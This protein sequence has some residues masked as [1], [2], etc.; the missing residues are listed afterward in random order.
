MKGWIG[1]SGKAKSELKMFGTLSKNCNFTFEEQI[2]E[3]I[4]RILARLFDIS[5]DKYNTAGGLSNLPTSLQQ[6]LRM[7]TTQDY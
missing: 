4:R 3:N 2:L 5:T 1:Y 7:F 6:Q